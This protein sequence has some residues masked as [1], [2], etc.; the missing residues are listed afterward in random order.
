MTIQRLS[1]YSVK[2]SL[3]A[4]ELRVFCPD[5]GWSP[6]S[7]QTAGML[8]FLLAK[9][10]A[11]SGIAFSALPV[12]AELIC[13]KDGSLAVYFTVQEQPA[14]QQSKKHSVR[15]A[16]RF[17]D[18]EALRACCIQLE[19]QQKAVRSSMLFRYHREWILSLRLRREGTTA[20]RHI[21]LEYGS[22]YRLSALNKARLAE[23][24]SCVFSQDAVRRIIQTEALS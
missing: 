22:P 7:P 2:V 3:S 1:A 5:E 18:P 6:E 14:A 23:Y 19:K 8:S 9:A 21:L 4:E 16:A 11:V 20:V 12:T 13:A 10:E 24:G 15:L 17:S